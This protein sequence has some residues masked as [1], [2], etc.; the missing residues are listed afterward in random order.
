[1]SHEE[2]DREIFELFDTDGS[3]YIEVNDLE[4][5]GR[6]MG[7]K[8]EQVRELIYAMDPNHDGRV[9]F[10]EFL[11]ILRHIEQRLA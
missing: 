4:W 1:M 9:S 7:W 3:G 6:A 8:Q 5:V 10:E 2:L 11:L